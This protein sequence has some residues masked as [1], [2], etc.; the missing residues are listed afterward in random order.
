MLQFLK[1]NS[2]SVVDVGQQR[3]DGVLTTHYRAELS[4]DHL[5][6]GLPAAEGGAA[7]QALAML[8]QS[9]QSSEMP[10]EV[11]IDAHHLV[12]RVVMDLD[13]ELPIAGSMQESVAVDL[14]HYGPQ[15]RPTAPPAQQV[16]DLST[17]GS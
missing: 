4:L 9:L 11:W 10:V 17:L 5:A 14:S 8:K 6:A 1:S 2:A 7:E 3:V 13:L 16:T 12:R 15:H